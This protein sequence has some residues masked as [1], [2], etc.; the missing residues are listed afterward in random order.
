HSFHTG[1]FYSNEEDEHFDYGPA[2]GKFGFQNFTDFLLGMSAAQNGSPLGLSNVD[3]INANEGSGA[4]GEDHNINHTN[5]FATFLQ[6][7]IKVQPRFT[8]NLGLRWEYLMA[9]FDPHGEF[10][11]IWPDLISQVPIPPAGG[12][13]AGY[14]V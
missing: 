3:S 7:D 9:P 11:T 1:F 6:D 10:T 4:K 13:Y 14:T 8:L 2:R 12:T 5:S